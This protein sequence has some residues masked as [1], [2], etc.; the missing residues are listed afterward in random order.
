MVIREQK[1]TNRNLPATEQIRQRGYELYLQRG[2]GDGRDVGDWLAAERELTGLS[3][4]VAH[5][6]DA[7]KLARSGLE[8]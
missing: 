4:P 5:A 3:D 2:G 1:M 7:T 6:D 8:R